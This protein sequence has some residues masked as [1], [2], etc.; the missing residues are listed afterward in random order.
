MLL[1]N[2]VAIVTGGAKGMGRAISLKFA[3]EGCSVAVV[4]ISMKE[5]NVTVSDV[6]KK[7]REGLAINCDVTNGKQVNEMVEKVIAKFGKVDIL[8]NNA[9][10]AIPTPPVEKLSEEEWD[11]TIDL[12]L[13]SVFLCSRAVIPHMKKVKYG[14]IINISSLGAL[15]PLGDAIAYGAAKAGILGLTYGLTSTLARFNICVNAIL[16]GL[17]RTNFYDK[18]LE[19]MPDKDAFFAD[20]SKSIPLG[21]TGTPDDIAGAVL[22]FA[23][24]LSS[25]VTGTSLI[26]AGGEPLRSIIAPE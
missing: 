17:T 23:S 14:K 6:V 26:V 11:R 9:G 20:V 4:D 15:Y 13:K 10:A 8:V 7:G 1:S 21:R 24:P 18:L 12:N 3:E 16:P 22:F 19:G 5:A 25:F 2:R